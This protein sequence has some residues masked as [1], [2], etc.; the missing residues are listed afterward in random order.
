MKA[1]F[2][3]LKSIE[4][5]HGSV[6]LRSDNILV[7]RPNIATFR[8]YDIEVFK[9]LLEVFIEIT[10]GIPRPYLCDNRYVNGIISREEQTYINAHF[11]EFAT[12]MGMLTSSS[13]VKVI[14]NGYNAIFKPKVEI[15]LFKT[16]EDAVE[17]LLT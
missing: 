2:E 4:I 5:Q 13:V 10:E 7:F 3:I 11:H 16:E 14:L 9:D 15:R 6:V 1:E 8:N 12:R 17:W